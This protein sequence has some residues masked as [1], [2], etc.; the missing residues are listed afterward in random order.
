MHCNDCTFI[1]SKNLTNTWN[2]GITKIMIIFFMFDGAESVFVSFCMP[3]WQYFAKIKQ[4][5][6]CIL[7]GNLIYRFGKCTVCGMDDGMLQ[8]Y[9]PC[10][11]LSS[12]KKGSILSWKPRVPTGNVKM[13]HAV[14]EE[15]AKK[16]E[17]NETKRN[18]R[19]QSMVK[20][21]ILIQ[22]CIMYINGGIVRCTIFW[23]LVSRLKKKN[24]IA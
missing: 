14:L 1:E 19:T 7:F 21:L 3:S 20:I 13:F 5:Y 16:R 10:C 24:S 8:N 18:E 11:K 2:L 9:W 12:L 15:S 6:I 17:R 4:K 23:V 22:Y